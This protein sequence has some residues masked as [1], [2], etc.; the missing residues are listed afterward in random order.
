MS[1]KLPIVV[2]YNI[3]IS[4]VFGIAHSVIAGNTKWIKR[5]IYLIPLGMVFLC[6]DEISKYMQIK[7]IIERPLP[8]LNL[9]FTETKKD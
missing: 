2:R 9:N 3:G 1:F 4:I 5:Y 6:Y 7:K 8:R